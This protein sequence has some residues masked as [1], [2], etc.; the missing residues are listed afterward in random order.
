[1]KVGIYTSNHCRCFPLRV[2][3]ALTLSLRTSQHQH[4][5]RECFGQEGFPHVQGSCTPGTRA[6]SCL[7]PPQGLA[8]LSLLL[9]I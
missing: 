8:A 2:S 7:H 4:G 1:M 9:G 3:S 5:W 6:A